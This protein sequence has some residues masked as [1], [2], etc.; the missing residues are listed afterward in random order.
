MLLIYL[1]IQQTIKSSTTG[2]PIIEDDIL[3]Y[4]TYVPRYRYLLWNA[5]NNIN[6]LNNNCNEQEIKV[7]FE[8]KNEPKSNGSTNG[9]WLTHPTF[10]F[11]ES[12]LN[13]IWVGK[14]TTSADPSSTCYT[15]IGTEESSNIALCN[16][17]EILPRVKPNVDMWRYTQVATMWNATRLI[18]NSAMYGLINESNVDSHMMKNIEWGAVAYLSHSKYVNME[19]IT[20]K[21]KIN[22]Y[23]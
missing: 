14:F 22:R 9:E 18:K 7:I 8:R 5:N 10:T 19:M 2:T 13:G 1:V 20:I 16:N 12:E 3:A 21:V 6:C 17:K 11:G 23:I 15:D 4:Y